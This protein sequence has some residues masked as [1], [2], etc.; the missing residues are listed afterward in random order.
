MPHSLGSIMRSA[1]ASQLP[2]GENR[3]PMQVRGV[4]LEPADCLTL[5]AF[6]DRALRRDR[7]LLDPAVAGLLRDVNACALDER[8]RRAEA[9]W[10]AD[11]LPIAE[12][13]ARSGVP[14]RTLRSRAERGLLAA[15]KD[16]RA[17]WLVAP[18]RAS[19]AAVG[20]GGDD[21]TGTQESSSS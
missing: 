12:A 9:A 2:G 14:A 6:A 7:T 1:A 3:L 10:R 20:T 15:V 21:H 5:A 19:A 4:L 13:S 18:N 8:R 11:L 17:R 16:E